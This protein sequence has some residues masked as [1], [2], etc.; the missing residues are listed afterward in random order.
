MKSIS[1]PNFNKN[2]RNIVKDFSEFPVLT[3]RS[4]ASDLSARY[5]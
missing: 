4:R 1:L 5:L 3:S 2:V